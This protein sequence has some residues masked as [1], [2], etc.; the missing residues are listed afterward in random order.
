MS[1]ATA[2]DATLDATT[3]LE[4]DDDMTRALAGPGAGCGCAHPGDTDPDSPDAYH[5]ADAVS[6][7]SVLRA[8]VLASALG[9]TMTVAGPDAFTRYAFADAGYTGHT[10]VVLSLRGGFDGMAAVA[11]VA[12]P[13]YATVRPTLRLPVGQAIALTSVFGMHP[14]MLPLKPWWDAGHLGFV[15]D[16]GQAAPTRSH[17]DAMAEMER[18]APGTGLRSGWLDRTVA[19]RPAGTSFQAT[20]VGSFGVSPGLAGP[21]PE[22][23][24][25]RIDGTKL[26]G[27][28]TPADQL[29]WTNAL[30]AMYAGTSPLLAQPVTTCL[31]A[32]ATLA[33]VQADLTPPAGG[34]VY[35]TG[36]DGKLTD[37]SQSLRDVARLVK[38][39]VGLQVATIDW[40]DWDMHVDAGRVGSGWMHGKL[41][42]L[43]GA[44]AAFAADLGPSL[45]TT[46]VVTL[47][48]FGRRVDENGSGGTDH[49]HGN[50]MLLLGGGIVGKTVHGTWS[51]L[52]QSQLVQGD[53]P[54]RNDYRAVLG[55]ILTRRCG[56]ATLGDVFPGFDGH[57]LGVVRA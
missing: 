3:G 21:T 11:P 49:G 17:F 42:E 5:R 18:A 24:L 57:T 50:L 38:A 2:L 29:K 16:V 55:E 51:G 46:N 40:G 26:S 23:A 31:G 20:Q 1:N 22:M 32:L 41:A 28:G 12:D 37:L 4:D 14:A 9:A 33:T 10:L 52:A 34:A 30:R 48:E 53:L 15:H 36:S 8:G 47:S 27:S 25:R 7:R 35:P 54:G 45:D 43:S 6:R 56:A 13:R 19:A 39:G 44:L